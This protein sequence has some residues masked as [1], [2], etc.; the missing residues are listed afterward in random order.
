ML[1]SRTQFHFPVA[2]LFEKLHLGLL[3]VVLTDS[4]PLL[5]VEYLTF[6]SG[7]IFVLDYFSSVV[8][9]L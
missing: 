9:A 7:E 6:F 8:D 5:K 4:F 2:N 1:I 3:P